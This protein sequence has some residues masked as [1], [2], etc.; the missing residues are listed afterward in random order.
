[1]LILQ[2]QRL[3]KGLDCRTFIITL[4]HIRVQVVL[5]LHYQ[6]FWGCIGWQVFDLNG[7]R[8]EALGPFNLIG[9]PI[10]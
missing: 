4:N 2:A 10:L 3:I 5:I 1:M 9:F 8:L 7:N 6:N